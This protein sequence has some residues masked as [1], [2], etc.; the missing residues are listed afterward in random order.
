MGF[1]QVKYVGV[2]AG[3]SMWEDGETIN[4]EVN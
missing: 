2:E 4:Q 3:G 1:I